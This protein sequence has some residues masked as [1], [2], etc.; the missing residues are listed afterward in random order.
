MHIARRFELL[1]ETYR[2][3][4]TGRRWSGPDFKSIKLSGRKKVSGG[5]T[6]GSIEDP[7]L[8]LENTC[9]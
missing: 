5:M 1:L 2:H 8:H 7:A 4:E 9:K 6:T 3:P